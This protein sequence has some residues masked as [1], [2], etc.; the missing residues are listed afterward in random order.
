MAVPYTMTPDWPRQVAQEINSKPWQKSNVLA[1]KTAAYTI[2]E[3]DDF[4]P[5]DATGAAFTVTLPPADRFVGLEFTIKKVD[6]SVN[7]VTIDGNAAETI[8]GAATVPLAAQWES[9]TVIS[10]GSNWLTR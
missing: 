5:C 2:V 9:R 6:A 8:D 10:N 4:V 7:V 3:G 1:N